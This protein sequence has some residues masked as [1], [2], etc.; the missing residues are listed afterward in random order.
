VTSV[1]FFASFLIL[2][3]T[4][5]MSG[6]TVRLTSPAPADDNWLIASPQGANSQSLD[7]A[8]EGTD[9]DGGANDSNF[10]VG[11]W[12]NGACQKSNP[13]N[14][15]SFPSGIEKGMGVSDYNVFPPN[16]N[17]NLTPYY[18]VR[19]KLPIT[20]SKAAS[21][22][23]LSLCAYNA[24]TKA[25]SIITYKVSYGEPVKSVLIE[26]AT[27]S[28]G[29]G[30]LQIKGRVVPNGRNNVGGSSVILKDINGN[31]LAIGP[32]I[33]KYF[34]FSLNTSSNPGRV[35]AQVVNTVSAKKP[36]INTR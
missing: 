21:S 14:I 26:K 17:Y 34:N 12:N 24:T 19:T 32:V 11:V 7:L 15:L 23:S 25:G 5:A 4:T 8:F 18:V 27:Y 30:T 16:T 28:R 9:T 10:W 35:M 36:V 22:T 29:T 1:K 6:P 13:Y 20:I 33:V 3:S 31:T 2:V